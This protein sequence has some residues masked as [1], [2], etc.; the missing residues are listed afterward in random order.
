MDKEDSFY[1]DGLKFTCKMCSY[2]CRGEP[3]FVYISR[4]DLDRFLAGMNLEAGEFIEKYCRWVPYYD[5]SEV[6]CLKETKNNDCIFWNNGC[7]AYKA[8]PLQCSTYPFWDFIVENKK[9]WD[10]AAADCPGINSGELH[11]Y[12]EITEKAAAY[13]RNRPIK[14][15]EFE[16]KTVQQVIQ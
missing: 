1:K 16:Q 7:A 6:L 10:E 9:S 11:S 14:R 15:H 4:T 12:E 5:G 3:G 2:C 8:R 13:R